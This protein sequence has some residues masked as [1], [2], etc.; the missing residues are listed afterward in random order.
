MNAL[1]SSDRHLLKTAL[2]R[3]LLHQIPGISIL[4]LLVILF[5]SVLDF[6]SWAVWMLVGAWI[7]KEL[8]TVPFTWRLYVR[9]R[10]SPTDMLIGQEAVVIEHLDPRG[11]V[12]LH[13]ELWAAEALSGEKAI[14]KGSTVI[15]EGIR[16]MTLIVK[17]K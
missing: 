2:R 16:D 3:Y 10:L 12:K 6:P 13:G 8:F 11:F 9:P 1:L 14:P 17:E 4:I 7:L 5:R 15:V